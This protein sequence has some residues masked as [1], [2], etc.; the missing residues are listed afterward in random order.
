[1][2]NIRKSKLMCYNILLDTK[3]IIKLCAQLMQVIN[4]VVYLR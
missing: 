4:S 1:M 2:F 3:L